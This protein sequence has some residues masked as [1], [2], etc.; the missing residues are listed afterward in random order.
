[1]KL[2]D[3]KP[4]QRVFLS[5]KKVDYTSFSEID[6]D[7]EVVATVINQ[8]KLVTT[9]GFRS[10]D[11]MTKATVN[12]IF[13]GDNCNRVDS[14]VIRVDLINPDIECQFAYNRRFLCN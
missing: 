2:K 12:S 4:G 5:L 6:I 13:A 7:C 14:K 1:M 8:C 3:V 9:I 10:D 11:K